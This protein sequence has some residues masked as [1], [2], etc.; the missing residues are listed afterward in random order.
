MP[1]SAGL[2]TTANRLSGA[3]PGNL[4]QSNYAYA[5]A[6]GYRLAP[7]FG[8]VNTTEGANRRNNGITHDGTAGTT[9]LPSDD[10]AA[11][12][13]WNQWSTGHLLSPDRSHAETGFAFGEATLTNSKTSWNAEHP[14]VSDRDL[15]Y[16][17]LKR[18]RREFEFE[19]LR[20][21]QQFKECKQQMEE[22]RRSAKT[23]VRRDAEVERHCMEVQRE[24]E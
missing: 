7:I 3:Q 6:I 10:V 20:Q 1:A 5:S 18:Q 16:F 15:D 22:E 8:G 11:D 12:G 13:E 4:R 21:Q 9:E 17:V 2:I 24:I 19:K 23:H 14:G